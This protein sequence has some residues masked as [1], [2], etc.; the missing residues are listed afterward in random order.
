M[1]S[2]LPMTA[3][4]FQRI[5]LR[6][7]DRLGMTSMGALPCHPERNEVKSK[8]LYSNLDNILTELPRKARDGRGANSRLPLSHLT[9]VRKQGKQS[10][11]RCFCAP[12]KRARAR[13]GTPPQTHAMPR[14]FA[15]FTRLIIA[16]CNAAFPPH[17]L[18]AGGIPR[19]RRSGRRLR[20]RRPPPAPA[21]RPSQRSAG[22]PA[23]A[24]RSRP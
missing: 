11:Q 15:A 21:D 24:F 3:Y 1:Q 20:P 16:F 4:N 23:S 13:F 22:S 9:R 10:K 8:D 14:K 6:S 19:P 17:A 5:R 12:C 7:L 18:T 2:V